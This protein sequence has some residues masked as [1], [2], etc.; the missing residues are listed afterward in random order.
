[1]KSS[2]AEV[3]KT[4]CEEIRSKKCMTE[5]AMNRLSES[6]GHRLVKALTTLKEGRVKKYVF[7]PSDRIVWIVVGRQRDYIVLPAAFCSCIDFF[8]RFDKGHLC[9]HII[10]QK[11]A[12]ATEK[13][14]LIE[15]GDGFYEVLMNE[16]KT[17]DV[18]VSKKH[19]DKKGNDQ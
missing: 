17:V 16:W 12:E 1:M 2:E 11:L 8:F 14:D 15:D 9:Y 10:A 19:R 5:A 13:F 7:K 6:F 3:L 18:N 4:I